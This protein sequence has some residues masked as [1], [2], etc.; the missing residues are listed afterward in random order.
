MA[1]QAGSALA[2]SD[3]GSASTSLGMDPVA[4]KVERRA[5]CAMARCVKDAQGLS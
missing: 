3:G 5:A 2:D 1:C 4:A